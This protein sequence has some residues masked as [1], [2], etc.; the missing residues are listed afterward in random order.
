MK[1]KALKLLTLA[2]LL[3]A[4][5]LPVLFLSGTTSSEPDPSMSGLGF[6]NVETLNANYKEWET[7]YEKE[8]GD[9]NMVL[10]MG[11]FKGLS[12]GTSYA[13]GLAK[14]NLVDGNVTVAING[15]SKDES[16]DVWMVDSA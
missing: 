15:L 5:A 3:I 8:G 10:A 1:I 12:T 2:F 14:F 6:G 7:Q 9:R 16:W 13:S 4:C 11:W